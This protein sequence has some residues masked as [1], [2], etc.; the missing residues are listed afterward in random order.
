NFYVLQLTDEHVRTLDAPQADGYRSAELVGWAAPVVNLIN[1]RFVLNSGDDTDSMAWADSPNQIPWY[2]ASRSSYRVGCVTVPGN[3]DVAP[4]GNARH[5]VTTQRW[6]RE[7]G[8]RTISTKLG[9]FYVLAHD[10]HDSS[11]KSW[12]S[13]EWTRSFTDPSITY[14]LMTQHFTGVNYFS[15]PS[16]KYP[17][18]M[19]LGHLHYNLTSQTTPYPILVNVAALS[20]A[21]SGFH[22]FRKTSTGG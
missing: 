13:T 11:L 19:L 5:A 17:N 2:K 14:R 15:P 10:F 6:D 3:H 7:M 22:D 9:S 8:Y 16:G 20:R 12:A 4:T 21:Q 18:L 1:P